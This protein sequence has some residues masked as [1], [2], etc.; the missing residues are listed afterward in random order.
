MHHEQFRHHSC[1]LTFASKSHELQDRMANKES[2]A[3]RKSHNYKFVHKNGKYVR[4]PGHHGSDSKAETLHAML[5]QA[6]LEQF[7]EQ[8]ILDA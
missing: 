4:V 1:A 5:K 8:D 2:E 6:G 3:N 7:S